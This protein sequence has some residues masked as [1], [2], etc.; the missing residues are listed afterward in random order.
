M[1]LAGWL[2]Q[3]ALGSWPTRHRTRLAPYPQSTVL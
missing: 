2:E 1:K 3:V